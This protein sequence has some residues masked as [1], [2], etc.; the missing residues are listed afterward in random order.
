M[1][2]RTRLAAV[3]VA[4][5]ALAAVPSMA[6]AAGPQL[7]GVVSGSPYGASGGSMAIPVLFSKMTAHSTGLQSPV[8]VIILKRNQRV[9]LPDGTSALPVNLRT[10]DRFKGTGAISAVNKRT[11]Y[12]R[13][14][15]EKGT[16]VYFR[17]KE[18]S[19]AELTAAVDAL[20]KA[21]A[22]LNDKLLALQKYTF[23]GFQQLLGEIDG[24]KRQLA[25]LKI[26]EGVDLT[27]LQNQINDLKTQL[28]GVIDSLKDYAKLTDVDKKIADA[29][30]GLSLLTNNDVT[31]NVK[32]ILNA[33]DFNTTALSQFIDDTVQDLLADPVG[34]L[35]ATVNGLIDDKINDLDL[36]GTY[37][38]LTQLA[39][40]TS[41]LNTVCSALKT[42]TVT[43][44]PD[45]GGILPPV[46]APVTLP[47][48]AGPCP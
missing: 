1:F 36:A 33:L 37:A 27:G 26:P 2:T 14:P 7:R 24:L 43:L 25:A 47:G 20:R 5:V 9:K 23:A 31:N 13:V 18:M 19:L 38:T 16:Q 17:S 22:D 44:D 32:N 12:P 39:A 29:I 6:T 45:G 15:M 46:Q 10:G 34:T 48:I 21:L 41:R 42:A 4:L 3:V 28:N 40:V 35:T 8:G 11:F 30:A